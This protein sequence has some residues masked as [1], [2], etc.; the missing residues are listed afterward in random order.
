MQPN[1]ILAAGCAPSKRGRPRKA[2]PPTTVD[3]MVDA[4]MIWRVDLNN[5]DAVREVLRL[6]RFGEVE[7]AALVDIAVAAAQARTGRR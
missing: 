4:L 2:T 1:R 3:R 6:S 5:A 7:I